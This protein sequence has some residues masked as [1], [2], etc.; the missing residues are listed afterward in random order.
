MKKGNLLKDN[1]YLEK[2]DKVIERP[3]TL[4]TK[5]DVVIKMSS[6]VCELI[7]TQFCSSKEN[8]D[9][10]YYDIFKRSNNMMN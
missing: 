3:I 10:K 6:K 1:P 4:D 5:I 2:I 9:E 7:L 8:L